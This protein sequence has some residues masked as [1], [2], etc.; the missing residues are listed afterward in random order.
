MAW[1]RLDDNIAQHP[2]ITSVDPIAAYL[3]I[4]SIAFASRFLS[5]GFIPASSVASLSHI[6]Y[7]RK[8]AR[9]LVKARLWDEVDGGFQIHDYHDFNLTADEVKEKRRLDAARKV[10]ERNPHGVPTESA[11]RPR[12]RARDP[13][14][15]HPI[16]VSNT[17]NKQV[18][19]VGVSTTSSPNGNG[20]DRDARTPIERVVAGLKDKP[21]GRKFHG[22]FR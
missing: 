3:W 21:G 22:R 2:K 8:Y 11:R 18:P 7:V 17:K 14:P 15:S 12:A 20:A 10:S 13:I 6:R 4:V 16:P 5:N 9:Q 19:P 1:V